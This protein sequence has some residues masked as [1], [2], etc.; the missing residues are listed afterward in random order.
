MAQFVGERLTGKRVNTLKN[1]IF[2]ALQKVCCHTWHKFKPFEIHLHSNYMAKYMYCWMLAEN[3]GTLFLSGHYFYHAEVITTYSD[4]GCLVFLQSRVKKLLAWPG[5]EPPTLNLCCQSDDFDHSLRQPKMI[6]FS[7]F[8]CHHTT[9]QAV[10]ERKA[11]KS[12]WVSHFLARKVIQGWNF[13]H[14]INL[15][16]H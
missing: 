4:W 3:P 7:F 2:D 10:R 1:W 16:F 14:L 13:W 12:V 6:I 8:A 9:I 5:I 15:F 11:L